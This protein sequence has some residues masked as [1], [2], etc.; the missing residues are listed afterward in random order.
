[1][2]STFGG[3]PLACAAIKTILEVIQEEEL[4]AQV[5]K[6]AALIQAKCVCGPVTGIQGAGFLIGLKTEPPAS[7][8]RDALLEN[9]ILTGTSADPHVLRLLPPLI[10]EDQHVDSLVQ[11]LQELNCESLQ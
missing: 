2:G 6:V 4:L 11:A 3:G 7:R 1:M 5:R 8:V 10:L 9:N